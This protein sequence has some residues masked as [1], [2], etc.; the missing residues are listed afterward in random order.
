MMQF[1]QHKIASNQVLYPSMSSCEIDRKIMVIQLE[2]TKPEPNAIA[3]AK[4]VKLDLE[5][6]T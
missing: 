6:L 3:I 5:K 4:C 1:G 2:S